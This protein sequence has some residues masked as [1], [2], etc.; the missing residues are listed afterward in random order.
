MVLCFTSLTVSRGDEFESADFILDDH[1]A[2]IPVLEGVRRVRV[3]YLNDEKQWQ[4]Y[5]MAHLAGDEGQIKL[6]LPDGIS[7]AHV[8]VE[9]SYTDPFPYDVYKGRSDF[10]TEAGGS[11]SSLATMANRAGAGAFAEDSNEGAAPAVQES[12]L[13]KWKGETLYFYNQLRG[14][15]V[16]DFSDPANPERVDSI[17]MPALGEDMYLHPDGEHL[18]L[19]AKRWSWGENTA[20][21]EAVVIRHS[22]DGLAIT[23]RI[24]LRGNSVVE[25]RMVGSHLYVAMRNS[26]RVETTGEDLQKIVQWESGLTVEHTNLSDPTNPVTSESLNLFSADGW[27]YNAMVSATSEYFIVSPNI[28]DRE[29]QSYKSSIHLIDIRD[30]GAP[31]EIAASTELD[32]HLKDKF[33]LRIRDNILT[34]ITQGGRWNNGLKTIVANYDLDKRTEE[35]DI[36]RLDHLILA[37]EETLFATRFDGDR[38]YVVTAIQIDPLFVVDLS[39]DNNLRLLGELKIPGWSHYLQPRGDRLLSVGVE[40][41]RVAI[42]QFDVS[43][44]ENLGPPLRVYLGEEGSYSWSEGNYD[45]QAIGYFPDRGVMILPFQSYGRDWNTSETALQILT[46]DDDSLEKAGV[47]TTDFAARRATLIEDT[48]LVSVSGREVNALDVSELSE[49][50]L[51]SSVE[52]AWTVDRVIPLENH[53]LQIEAGGYQW[54]RWYYNGNPQKVSIRITSDDA[55]DTVLARLELAGGSVAGVELL[56]DFLHV[57]T[58]E[59]EQYEIAEDQLGWRQVTYHHVVDLTD[60][61]GPIV[62][63]SMRSFKPTLHGN[64]HGRQL[65]SDRIAWIPE[66]NDNY[67]GRWMVDFRF[68]GGPGW[69]GQT[70]CAQ[71][72]IVDFSDPSG[73][74]LA[75]DYQIGVDSE[76]AVDD[77]EELKT[78]VGAT[79][80]GIVERED[81]IY[82][83]FQQNTL[84][85]SEGLEPSYYRTDHKLRVVT[86]SGDGVEKVAAPVS[87]PGTVEGVRDVDGDSG[88]LLLSSAPAIQGDGGQR[89][90][91]S[92]D[93]VLQTSAFDGLTAFLIDEVTIPNAYYNGLQVTDHHFAVSNYTWQNVETAQG[94]DFYPFDLAG[95]IS[96]PKLMELEFHPNELVLNDGILSA[97]GWASNQQVWWML[98]SG[99]ID[100]EEPAVV[101]IPNR[102]YVNFDQTFF[103]KDRSLAWVPVGA[104]GV[105]TVD[106]ASLFREPAEAKRSRS[107][108]SKANNRTWVR[109]QLESNN[110]TSAGEDDVLGPLTSD[111]I[112]RYQPVEPLTYH[113]WMARRLGEENNPDF[114]PPPASGDLDGDG[115][116]NWNEFAFG[117]NPMEADTERMRIQGAAGD[118]TE[119]EF[120][121]PR[122]HQGVEWEAQVSRNLTDWETLSVDA[123]S[124]KVVDVS[125]TRV[126]LRFSRSAHGDG[127]FF[128]LNFKR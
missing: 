118:E 63:D 112:W 114:V 54:S 13:W 110:L 97:T 25:S 62:G 98:D 5:S 48:T 46:F 28:Y 29:A 78:A 24:Q 4:A 44:P 36:L 45:E 96:E 91:W 19:L 35:G 15:Q 120:D 20:G 83:T 58:T 9:V 39:D 69:Y 51:L 64:Y 104:Y 72:F 119:I 88:L 125:T 71:I 16:F 99:T 6:R 32:G 123:V 100:N 86:L 43:D 75:A 23:N 52:A 113:G 126:V 10:V 49:P 14:L 67:W 84:V 77:E 21:S 17:R 40:D 31:L 27:W 82:L 121:L 74:I 11:L 102:F 95:Q 85:E 61:T 26:R 41:R 68:G 57:L 53:V 8:R 34:C 81:R 115:R 76:G 105:E 18:I 47:I 37:P 124:A 116:S 128:R 92:N 89:I 106:I 66:I 73:P 111:E 80:S 33:K 107:V 50:I 7:L 56:G 22:A 79:V 117:T 30:Q 70:T 59:S 65:E 3:S 101:Q 2:L 38:V 55:L 109:Y 122:G 103:D 90:W 42:S 127:S 93:L 94:I 12:D 60:P 1:A 87:V 108:R